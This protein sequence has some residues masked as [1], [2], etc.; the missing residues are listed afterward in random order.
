V[1]LALTWCAATALATVVTWQGVSFVGA[2]V[3]NGAMPVLS[4]AAIEEALRTTKPSRGSKRTKLS[5][6]AVEPQVPTATPTAERR[7]SRTPTPT[8]RRAIRS[9]ATAAPRAVTS[10]WQVAGGQVSAR[11][12][13]QAIALLYAT[14]TDGWNME[15]EE[16][17]PGRVEVHYESR[18]AESELTA[19]CVGGRPTA[20]VGAEGD[21]TAQRR[22]TQDGWGGWDDDPTGGGETDDGVHDR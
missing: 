19:R 15:I 22:E 10:T 13:G 1:L 2:R 4:Q 18:T 17:G 7:P 6:P 21:A 14:P 9:P 8:A 5:T 12:R 3:T 20:Q 16:D 11:C